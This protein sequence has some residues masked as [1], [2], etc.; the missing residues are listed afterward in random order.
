MRD[1]LQNNDLKSYVEKKRFRMSGRHW[2]LPTVASEDDA[3]P[4]LH[5]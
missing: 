1:W 5:V 3:D 2:L 4:N